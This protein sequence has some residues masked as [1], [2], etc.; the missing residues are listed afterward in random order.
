MTRT[1]T[2]SNN[3]GS[4][5]NRTVLVMIVGFRCLCGLDLLTAAPCLSPVSTNPNYQPLGSCPRRLLSCGGAS[6]S[7]V[8]ITYN[9]QCS[10]HH[11]PS[12]PMC[13]QCHCTRTISVL[14]LTSVMSMAKW[15]VFWCFVL[16]H[17]VLA[18]VE[19]TIFIAPDAEPLPLD[20][21]IDNLFL[22]RLSEQHP[23]VRVSISASFPTKESPKGTQTWL[24][25]EGLLPHNR[26]DVRICWL[27]TV[28]SASSVIAM[29][30]LFSNPRLSGSTLTPSREHLRHQ[31]C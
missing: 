28:G 15:F 14:P 16:L 30:D 22:T 2:S 25:I 19:K 11:H 26:Y 7:T 18:N 24:L 13:S 17:Q 21:S 4:I 8:A 9:S 20:A 1:M 5:V 12:F 3:R 23:S 31:S 6:C 27:A 10:Q 29:T